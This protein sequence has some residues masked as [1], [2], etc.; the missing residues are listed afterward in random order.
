VLRTHSSASVAARPAAVGRVRRRQ[1]AL[2]VVDSELGRRISDQ[3]APRA[4][5]TGSQPEPSRRRSSRGVVLLG[6]RLRLARCMR[7]IAALQVGTRREARVFAASR[8]V[9]LVLQGRG[10]IDLGGIWV[11]T[12]SR[13]KWI[14]VV[15]REERTCADR[16]STGARAI[17]FDRP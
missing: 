9:L 1:A 11:P 5:E 6:L 7:H 15:V 12:V 17:R 10:V 14:G 3:A 16:D 4:A 2:G 13:H 8:T